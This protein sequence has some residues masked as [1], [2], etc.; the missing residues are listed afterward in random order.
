MSCWAADCATVKGVAG[1]D[2]AV[3]TATAS[4]WIQLIDQGITAQNY[5]SASKT[6]T[7]NFDKFGVAQSAA[8]QDI[9][10]TAS[11][12]SD[13]CTAVSTC[14]AANEQYAANIGGAASIAV[15][16]GLNTRDV[17]VQLY[18]NSTYDTVYADVTRNTVGQV[19]V[20]FTTAPAANAIR[21][22]ITKV[23]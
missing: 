15:N 12:V 18:D 4:G 7:I 14:I 11:Q 17:I 20:D 10:I 19:T 5:G 1:F 16:H 9:D 22:L 8:Q 13:F 23:S 6:V 3:F 2:N 21:I